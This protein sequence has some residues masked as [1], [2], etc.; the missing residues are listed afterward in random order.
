MRVGLVLAGGQSRRMGKDKAQLV[1][2]GEGITLAQNARAILLQF[3]DSV[4]IS[5]IDFQDKLA[6]G[7]GPLAGIA[8]GIERL[9]ECRELLISA[10]DMPAL[11]NFDWISFFERAGKAGNVHLADSFFPILIRDI[12][13]CEDWLVSELSNPEGQRSIKAMLAGIGSGAL[14]AQAYTD[15][16]DTPDEWAD[17]LAKRG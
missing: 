8:A 1:L 2:P 9:D 10:V 14:P 5:G 12:D 4:E 3:C 7:E 16:I 6:K 13:L 11:E 15:N 17:F